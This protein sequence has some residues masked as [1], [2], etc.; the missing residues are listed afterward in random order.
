MHNLVLLRELPPWQPL[1]EFEQRLKGGGWQL[2]VLFW[3][4]H[5]LWNA[6]PAFRGLF[7]SGDSY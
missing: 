7:R 5:R 1:V 2:Y 4:Q 3:Q 6:E